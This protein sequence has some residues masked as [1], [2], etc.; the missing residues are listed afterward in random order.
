MAASDLAGAAARAA[1]TIHWAFD[2]HHQRERAITRR[3]Q[4]RFER[5]D[6][7]GIRQD[8]VERL[9]LH[10]RS[11]GRTRDTLA[12]QLGER[13]SDPA[14]WAAI[15][16]AYTH[17]I[18]GRNDFELAQ[19]Y[20]N[21]LVRRVFPETGVDPALHYL[22][23]DV[24]LP[25]R[26]WEM[27]SARM[28]A[29]R[30][31]DA[32]VVAKA[33][34][35]AGLRAPF[36]DLAGDAALAAEHIERAVYE[37]LGDTGVEAFDVLRPV[38]FRNKGAYV[39]GRAR[40]GGEVVPL[41]L[42]LVNGERGIEVDAVL[43]GQDDASVVFSF[44]RWYFHADIESPREVIGFL[45]SILPR[46]RT[47]E[48]YISLGYTK[49]GKTEFYR[50]LTR[51]IAA[52]EDPFVVARG[53]RGLVMAVFTL[54]SYEFVF[55]IIKDRFPASKRTTRARVMGKYREVLQRDRV[56]RLVDFQEFEHLTFPRGRFA[57]GLA[58]E[59]ATVASR[60]VA[61]AG[62]RVVVRHAYVERRVTPLDVYLAEAPEERCEAVVLDWGTS[63]KDLAAADIF[64]GD[65]LLKNFGVTRHGRVV[66][67]DYDE[68]SLLTECS[69]LPVP[70]PRDE[71]EELAAEPFY[72]VGEGDVFPEE[73]RTFLG[74]SGR[75]REV[76]LAAHSDLFEVDFWRRMQERNRSGEVI[77]F[78]PYGADRRLAPPPETF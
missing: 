55:K 33:L 29:V 56:G 5:R 9:D 6:W 52:T 14:A 16:E 2:E 37:H 51:Q 70:Q 20:F 27:A 57:P 11:V 1:D 26:G 23:E 77:D 25:Y 10:S 28:Y 66:F 60:S 24:P 8:T 47:P 71:I 15:K 34:E 59:L 30:R 35:D 42:A 63:L 73:L 17:A 75:L 61:L 62:D 44:A 32:A 78:F 4:G 19:T 64:P 68:L 58:E 39:V 43:H 22:A 45:Q 18:I 7:P 46:K 31:I 36:R 76:F 65:V 67:Y 49:H 54:P 72:A 69:F 41:L 12:E 40:R 38:F 50:D 53:Q 13:L 74:L 48:L 3:V 21:S